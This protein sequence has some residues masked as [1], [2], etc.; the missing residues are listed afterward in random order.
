[1]SATGA[2]KPGS[3]VWNEEDDRGIALGQTCSRYSPRRH[4][5]AEQARD[6]HRRGQRRQHRRDFDEGD[7]PAVDEA[8]ERH[9]RATARSERRRPGSPALIEHAECRCARHHHRD[10]RQI[11]AAGNDDDRHPAAQDHQ[12]RRI[13]QDDARDCRAWRSLGRSAEKRTISASV[14]AKTIDS[15]R[16]PRGA[17]ARIDSRADDRLS[18]GN[19][20][21]SAPLVFENLPRLGGTGDVQRQFLEDPADLQHLRGA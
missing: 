6:E 21:L 5:E 17:P 3:D 12:G 7:Q 14:T 11:E 16:L 20:P 8:D 15:S 13:G 2:V 4:A 1:M 10:L 19:S 18:H 9:A